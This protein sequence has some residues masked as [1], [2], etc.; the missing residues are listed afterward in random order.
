MPEFAP[1]PSGASSEP[2]SQARNPYGI[3]L[4]FA[5]L[6]VLAGVYF[7]CARSG[8][9]WEFLQ[10]KHYWSADQ[11]YYGGYAGQYFQTPDGFRAPITEGLTNYTNLFALTETV[12]AA[13]ARHPV[14]GFPGTERLATPFLLSLWLRLPGETADV[15]HAFWQLNVLLWMVSVVLAYRAAALFFGDDAS[16]WFAAILMAL[17]PALTVTFG[18]IK[19]QSLGSIYLLLGMVL[20][21]GPLRGRAPF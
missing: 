9:D 14:Q 8:I 19:Q 5:L 10:T 12:G 1:D 13:Q 11:W 7:R 18:A 20:Y 16:P 21:E 6:A 17:Y 4:C 15:W 2:A 3:V